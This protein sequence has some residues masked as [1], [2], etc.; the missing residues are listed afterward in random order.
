MNDN[1]VL[2]QVRDSLSGVRMSTSAETI[3]TRARTRRH[4]QRMTGVTAGAAAAC[5]AL[6]LGLTG[7][8]SS[9]NAPPRSGHG[10]A[11]GQGGGQMRF[12]AFTITSG[13][14]GM[15]KLT[16]RKGARLDP[17]AL[18]RALARHG[19]HALVTVGK[20][21][22]SRGAEVVQAKAV[23]QVVTSRAT[24]QTVTLTINPA[25]LR[26]GTEVSIGILTHK[27]SLSVIK[28]DAKLKC[29]TVVQATPVT[30][31]ANKTPR[32]GQP[33]HRN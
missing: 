19:I 27:T 15:S 8:M 30:L 14:H 12:D 24:A 1:D 21:C 17:A 5:T 10:Q 23:D 7:I 9:G 13:P 18:R 32:S 33:A 28:S 16:L 22:G 11:Q 31:P 3:I 25:R 6:T 2:D 4:R 29:T 20:R 26:P